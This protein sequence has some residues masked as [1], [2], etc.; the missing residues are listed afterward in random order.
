MT[1]ASYGAV[2]PER[3]NAPVASVVVCWE[4]MA[5]VA[6]LTPLPAVL[7]TVPATVMVGG[8]FTVMVA[9]AVRV[10]DVAVSVAVVAEATLPGG[11]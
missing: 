1:M 5:T 9:L 3:L 11:V 4:P 7:T 8:G 6:P 10:P 2:T